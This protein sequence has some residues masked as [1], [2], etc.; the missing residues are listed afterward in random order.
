MRSAQRGQALILG[1]FVLV[2]GLAALF[3]LYNAGQLVRAKTRLVNTADAAAYSSGVLQARV[4]N[5]TAYNNRALLAN[6]VLVAQLV[7]A[8][9]WLPYAESHIQAQPTA[10]PECA[11]SQGAGAS[12]GA[13]F[14]YGP[15]YAWMCYLSV[16]SGGLAAAGLPLVAHVPE[17]LLGVAEEAKSLI[18][19]ALGQLHRP[20]ALEQLHDQLLQSL[21]DANEGGP[22]RVRVERLPDPSV[23]AFLHTHAGAER[24]RFRDLV[25]GAAALDPFV[26]ER[27]W[28]AEAL[29]PTPECFPALT[30]DAYNA[31]RRRGGTEMVGMDEWRAVDTASFHQHQLH[32]GKNILPSCELAERPLGVGAQKAHPTGAGSATAAGWWGGAAADN[33]VA[34]GM[35]STSH[36]ERY[37]GLPTYTDLSAVWRSSASPRWVQAV[38]LVKPQGLL[39]TTDQAGPWATGGTNRLQAYSTQAAAGEWVAVS[40]VQ[41]FFERPPAHAANQRGALTG[42]PQETGGLFNPYWQARLLDA[43]QHARVQARR[44]GVEVPW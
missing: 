17:L 27:R 33:P 4:L 20:G 36:W 10:F 9:A 14:Q 41:V 34:H 13:L 35:A 26:P 18:Q 1:L 37:S 15:G 28:D 30:F 5:F 16:Q 29:L 42:S 21:V 43:S 31:V 44:Q 3:Y 12:A 38:R 19:N 11:D 22:G 32:K 39:G 8:A 2:A 24:G 40:A 23:P 25:V 7:S 6:E